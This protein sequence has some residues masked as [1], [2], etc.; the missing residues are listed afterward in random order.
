MRRCVPLLPKLEL[1]ISDGDDEIQLVM[2][3]LTA[4]IYRFISLDDDWIMDQLFDLC[5]PLFSMG[6]F[7]NYGLEPPFLDV[8]KV[9][10]RSPLQLTMAIES[11]NRR[12][13][14]KDMLFIGDDDVALLLVVKQALV[15]K[16]SLT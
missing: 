4:L 2:E 6:Q 7:W 15:G 3:D 5:L 16:L 9:T 13:R 14:Q 12:I 11:I 1:I 10:A 8:L